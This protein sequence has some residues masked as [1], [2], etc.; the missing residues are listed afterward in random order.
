V[1]ENKI[2]AKWNGDDIYQGA[3]SEEKTVT[4][5]NV[6][7]TLYINKPTLN[8]NP[9][10]PADK[11]YLQNFTKELIFSSYYNPATKE[12]KIVLP[13]HYTLYILITDVSQLYAWQLKLYMSDSDLASCSP[14]SIW[15]PQNGVFAGTAEILEKK[16]EAHGDGLNITIAVTQTSPNPPYS[17]SGI[18]ATHTRIGIL[19]AINFTS[20]DVG[21]CG[22][23]WITE[24]ILLKTPTDQKIPY[25]MEYDYLE[26]EF[27][28][29]VQSTLE[30]STLTLDANPKKVKIGGNVTLTG[31]L[32]P[33]HPDV[34]ITI[35]VNGTE[36][37]TVKTFANS[38]Y[39]YVWT[40]NATG[41]YKLQASWKGTT[42][43]AK[44]D[45]DIVTVTVVSE[46]EEEAKE[47]Y[48]FYII[49]IVIIVIIA[50]IA[51]YFKKFRKPKIPIEEEST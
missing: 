18:N 31:T 37:I 14:D 46:E 17:V 43:V 41:T 2:K 28:G 7:T 50:G 21:T 10:A 16:I 3:T 36:L 1:G 39:R 25:R 24:N 22:I 32:K 23:Q 6:D 4:V 27:K 48:T 5:Q 47:D 12:R 51:V 13:Y 33:A 38:S 8:T 42:L 34:D 20:Y 15:I 26:A 35:K 9:S 49:I 29:E 45:S 40:P 19:C 30:S 44:D 11:L